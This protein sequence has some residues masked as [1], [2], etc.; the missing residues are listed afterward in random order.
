MPRIPL[1]APEMPDTAEAQ[2]SPAPE[3]VARPVPPP[4]FVPDT[5]PEVDDS[6][7]APAAAPIE[8]PTHAVMPPITGA[9]AAGP[10]MGDLL[11]E[12]RP[13]LEPARPRRGSRLHGLLQTI[14]PADEP[15]EI[16]APARSAGMAQVR[17]FHQ[18]MLRLQRG[19]LGGL[20]AM[21]NGIARLFGQVVPAPDE[22]GKQGIPT[23]V[24]VGMAIF[25]PVVIVVVVVGLALSRQGES[26][27]E[28]YRAR[29][30]E[31]HA[32]ALALSGGSC[33]NKALRDKWVEVHQLA[34]QAERLRPNDLEI[35]SIRADAQNYLDCFDDVERRNI[36]LMREFPRNA[37]LAGPI[38][39]PSGVDLY[40]LDKAN[41]LI[42]H[43]TLSPEG[44]KITTR[45]N[46]PVI[47]KGQA[48]GPFVVGDIFDIEWMASGGTRHDNVLIALDRSGVLVAYS[49]TFFHSAQQLVTEERWVNPVAIATFGQNLYVLDT[50]ADQ[51]WRY[52]PP[53]GERQYSR[54]PEEYFN[55]DV[56]P[57]LAEAVDFGIDRNGAVHILFRDG[58]VRKFRSNTQ[59]IVEEQPF[60]YQ[61]Q[62]T[63]ALTN[64]VVLFVDNDQA[65]SSLYIV[66]DVHDT[67]YETS[68]AGRY[69]TGYRPRNM[70]DVFQ[71]IT[72]FY[73][74]SVVRNNMYVLSG[75]KLYHFYRHEP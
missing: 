41:S 46:V 50:G 64:G 44:D 73:A 2:P 10:A 38:L 3:S 49:L 20:L 17:A 48:V 18:A 13:D 16:A 8:V 52:T 35:L 29:A 45:E 28:N 54:A 56:Q 1:S 59:G 26:E 19:V 53:P 66:D 23:N 58:S 9:P 5:L 51:I 69:N 21:V 74:D 27:F 30:K 33:E 32:T 62:P 15:E 43:D 72:G 60:S 61:R 71:A 63:G 57:D 7:P 47:F 6:R 37:V 42:Y 67:I 25:I 75:N 24:A 55:G 70:P 68:W 39:S 12:D 14:T 22:S 34:R 11:P 4:P 36:S 31:A 40:T 65:S